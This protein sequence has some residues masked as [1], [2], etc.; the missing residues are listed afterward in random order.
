M[1]QGGTSAFTT[2]PGSTYCLFEADVACNNTSV[3][4]GLTRLSLCCRRLLTVACMR[5]F[6]PRK[7]KLQSAYVATD[8]NGGN[9]ENTR[10]MQ[11]S[12]RKPIKPRLFHND[13][14]NDRSGFHI[15]AHHEPKRAL[16]YNPSGIRLSTLRSAGLRPSLGLVSISPKELQYQRASRRSKITPPNLRI[17]LA[18]CRIQTDL[19]GVNYLRYVHSARLPSGHNYRYVHYRPYNSSKPSILFLHGFPSSSYDWRR[20]FDYF[21]SHGYGILAPDL[22]GYGGSQK[23]GN[24]EAYTLKNQANDIAA[25]LDCVGVGKMMSVGHDL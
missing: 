19:N 23:P 20:Q 9:D 6:P 25:L 14:F 13:L 17:S 3:R 24:V 7:L 16:Q 4:S 8:G 2:I 1:L 10:W 11:A 22:L 5:F 18:Y 12:Y 21:A 15:N